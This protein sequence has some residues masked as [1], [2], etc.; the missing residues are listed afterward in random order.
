MTTNAV[1]AL[2]QMAHNFGAAAVIGGPL[3]AWWWARERP[4]TLT[5]SAWLTALGWTTQGLSGIGF[6]L[7]SYYSRGELPELA[8]VALLALYIKIGC[9]IVGFALT[10]YYLTAPAPRLERLQRWFWSGL[11]AVGAT[12]L[13]AAAFLRWFG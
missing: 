1:Y 6:A 9:V 11:C 7:T 8:G 12:A 10:G 4:A 13:S 3:T 5:A 2:V